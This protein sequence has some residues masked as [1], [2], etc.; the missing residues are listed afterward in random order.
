MDYMPLRYDVSLQCILDALQIYG[1]C[2][3][4]VFSLMLSLT[5]QC[6]QRAQGI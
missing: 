4:N 3:A 6:K 5:D 2:V 1:E